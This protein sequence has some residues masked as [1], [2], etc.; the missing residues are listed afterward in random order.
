MNTKKLF[1]GSFFFV[2][3]LLFLIN[4]LLS[5]E[6]SLGGIIKFWPLLLLIIGFNV[7]SKNPIVKNSLAVVGGIFFALMVFILITKPVSYVKYHIKKE[8]AVFE[9]LSESYGD[10]I[11]VVELFFSTGAGKFNL[12]SE[13]ENLY[14][15]E[16]N[17][18]FS[19]FDYKK[20]YSN[21]EYKLSI[22]PSYSDEKKIISLFDNDIDIT[23]NEN[24]LFDIKTQLGAAKG[25]IDLTNLKVKKLDLEI[26][27]TS[28]WLNLGEGIKDTL[29]VSISSGASSITI[30]GNK[31]SG[32]KILIDAAV[33]SKNIK[34]L[35][36]IGDGVYESENFA[37]AEKKCI[38]KIDAGVSNINFKLE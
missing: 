13:K 4:N 38:V 8:P 31:N 19:A 34:D 37:T 27:A 32:V 36:R 14:T 24:P 11:K 30:L 7:V 28:L 6:I 25:K 35:K 17:N 16:G 2:L 23:L 1:W 18:F 9:K 22:E 3:G 10:S 15:I 21:G 26:G 33:S 29:N 12:K 5:T 20:S